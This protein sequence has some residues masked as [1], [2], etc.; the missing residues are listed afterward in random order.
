MS[1]QGIRVKQAMIEAGLD[2]EQ[3][4]HEVGCTQGAISQIINGRS[5]R[6]RFLPDIA[7][8]LGVTEDYLRGLS[9]DPGASAP[10]PALPVIL[11]ARLE[12]TLGSEEALTQM[13]EGL[14]AGLDRDAP[15]ASQARLLARKLPIA[16]SSLRDLRSV[17][18]MPSDPPSAL[19]EADAD[20][21][22]ANPAPRP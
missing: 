19:S 1:V 7:R 4:A 14:L 17:S 8:R 6:S 18:E 3:L 15:R 13:F 22:I 10:L 12:V 2:Q 21:A 16:L 5:L 11:S 9:D 20:L